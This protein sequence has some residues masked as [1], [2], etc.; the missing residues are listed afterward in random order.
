MPAKEEQEDVS[1]VEVNT[2]VGVFSLSYRNRSKQNLC[3]RT[4]NVL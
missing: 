1:F 4:V 2:Q 3:F